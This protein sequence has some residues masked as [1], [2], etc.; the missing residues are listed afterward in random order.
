MSVLGKW[1]YDYDYH[2]RMLYLAVQYEMK[3]DE[4]EA[5]KLFPAY[6]HI[7]TVGERMGG[8]FEARANTEPI[9]EDISYG[10]FTENANEKIEERF[11]LLNKK[12]WVVDDEE[13]PSENFP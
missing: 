11:K 1:I 6:A 13:F 5:L 9:L 12:G 4:K 10:F 7:F 2:R 3:K 8:V